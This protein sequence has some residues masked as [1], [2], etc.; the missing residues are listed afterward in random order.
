MAKRKCL[1][2]TN[3]HVARLAQDPPP[4]TGISKFC[5]QKCL[6]PRRVVGFTET[7]VMSQRHGICLGKRLYFLEETG[8]GLIVE[9]EKG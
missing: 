2:P 9:E 4:L 6:E 5:G 3:S 7:A 1:W 8:D